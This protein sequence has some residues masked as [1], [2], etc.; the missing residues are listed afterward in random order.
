[1][2]EDEIITL[3]SAETVMRTGDCRAAA[4]LRMAFCRTGPC[5]T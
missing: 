4:M 1:M 2:K 3:F 5:I